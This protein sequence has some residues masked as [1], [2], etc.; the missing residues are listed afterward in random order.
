MIFS[1][2]MRRILTRNQREAYRMFC[3]KRKRRGLPLVCWGIYRWIA[4]QNTAAH[5]REF[6]EWRTGK[7]S[8]HRKRPLW[9]SRVMWDLF[10]KFQR[11]V[12]A[13][14]TIE[15][16]RDRR[17]GAAEKPTRYI[18]RPRVGSVLERS[19]EEILAKFARLG[20]LPKRVA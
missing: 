19:P 3:L 16:Y 14:I 20:L 2:H 13:D 12:R 17:M 1:D 4:P 9:C 10:R 5:R 11:E 15:E 6:V 8:E 18:S 7:P